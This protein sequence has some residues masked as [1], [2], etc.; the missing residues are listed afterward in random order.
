MRVRADVGRP[1]VVGLGV[2][3]DLHAERRGLRS[4]I[5]EVLIDR[6][7]RGEGLANETDQGAHAQWQ[8]RNHLFDDAEPGCHV[9]RIDRGRPHAFIEQKRRDADDDMGFEKAIRLAAHRGQKRQRLAGVVGDVD[10][11]ALRLADQLRGESWIDLI[12]RA[13]LAGEDQ[14]GTRG[15]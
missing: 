8:E 1:A 5:G 9:L 13:A 10:H 6:K 15:E 2:V 11:A 3:D 4:G 12:D 7:P 14:F